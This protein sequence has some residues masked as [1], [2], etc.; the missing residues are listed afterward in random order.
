MNRLRIM[1][2]VAVLVALTGFLVAGYVTHNKPVAWNGSAETLDA[3]IEGWASEGPIPGVLLH[4]QQ[5]ETVHY[6]N[7]AGALSKNGQTPLMP[8]MPF[9]TASVGKLFTAGTVLRLHERGILNIDEAAA[10]TRDAI[11]VGEDELS[12]CTPDLNATLKHRATA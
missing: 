11:G 5:G 6:S 12:P 1:L 10:A 7:A 9:H 4:I 8:M 2:P 3:H